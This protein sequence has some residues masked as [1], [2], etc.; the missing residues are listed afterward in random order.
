[1]TIKYTHHCGFCGESYTLIIPFEEY[2]AWEK[3]E[4]S[5]AKTIP[6]LTH[7]QHN[8]L[9]SNLCAHCEKD[10]YGGK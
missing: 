5:V 4:G 2:F 8:Q 10:Y 6:S 9:L 7:S 1:M 3:G